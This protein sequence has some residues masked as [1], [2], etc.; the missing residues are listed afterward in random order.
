[1]ET[2]YIQFYEFETGSVGDIPASWTPDYIFPAE[3]ENL[4]VSA[5]MEKWNALSRGDRTVYMLYRIYLEL[6]NFEREAD[7]AKTEDD[8]KQFGD[9]AMLINYA[10]YDAVRKTYVSFHGYKLELTA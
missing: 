7:R 8:K 9:F 2:T 3:E 6:I 1:M 5:Q 10:I 4:S